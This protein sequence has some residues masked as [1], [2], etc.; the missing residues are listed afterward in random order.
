MDSYDI[1]II[2]LLQKD[3]RL[4]NKQMAAH[5]GP[6]PSTC[7]ARTNALV[8]R[9]VVKGV[10]ARVDPKVMGVGIQAM[11]SIGIRVHSNSLF[12]GFLTYLRQLRE[13]HA[14]FHTSGAVDVLVHVMVRDSDHLRGF[15][16]DQISSRDEVNRCETSLIYEVERN[17]ILP[18]YLDSGDDG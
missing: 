17:D 14:L 16:L 1:K 18:N 9:K 4:S 7:L 5:V 2:E 15:V 8:Q 3:G 12:D 11:L 6:A 13:V 10:G